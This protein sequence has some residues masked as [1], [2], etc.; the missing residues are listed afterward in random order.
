MKRQTKDNRVLYFNDIPLLTGNFP[1]LDKVK[2]T[3]EFVEKSRIRIA[4]LPDLTQ[5]TAA[6]QCVSLQYDPVPINLCRS[7]HGDSIPL[8]GPCFALNIGPNG[9]M[10]YKER[11]FRFE[12]NW[13]I[14]VPPNAQIRIRCNNGW[15]L[16]FYYE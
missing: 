4:I 9:M 11:E 10:R 13:L 14:Y 16:H 7:I 2:W 1:H 12:T 3:P 5:I 15:V 8:N 6:V